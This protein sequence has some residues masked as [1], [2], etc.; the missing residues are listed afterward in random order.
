MPDE[1]S[2]FNSELKHT[3]TLLAKRLS[4]KRMFLL[5]I[6]Q[7]IGSAIGATIIAGIAIAIFFRFIHQFGYFNFLGPTFPYPLDNS[8]QYSE[9]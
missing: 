9:Y 4:Y 8:T 3:N 1:I 5:G 2:S 6:V 7:G